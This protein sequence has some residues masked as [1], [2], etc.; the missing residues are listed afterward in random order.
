MAMGSIQDML[1]WFEEAE[2][3]EVVDY[4][5]FAQGWRIARKTGNG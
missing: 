5:K 1:K 2:S 3:D 4:E